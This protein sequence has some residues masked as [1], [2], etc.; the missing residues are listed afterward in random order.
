IL[1]DLNFNCI[2]SRG[3]H[4]RYEK[5]GYG[6]TVGF[7]KEYPPKTA[8]SMLNDISKIEGIE[9]RELIKNYKIKI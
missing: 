5:N 9:Y 4:F 1:K 2:R 7:H 6:L 3:S 8:K